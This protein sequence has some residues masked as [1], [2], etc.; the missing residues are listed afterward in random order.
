M[1][2]L[3]RQKG[4]TKTPGSSWIEIENQLHEFHAGDGLRLG[5]TDIYEALDLLYED[6]MREGYVPQTSE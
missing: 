4:V 1:R 3:M 2:V 5:S 6:L